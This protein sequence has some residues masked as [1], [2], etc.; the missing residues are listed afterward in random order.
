MK[1]FMKI[2]W[3]KIFHRK[4]IEEKLFTDKGVW[5]SCHCKKCDIRWIEPFK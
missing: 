2:A 3:C 4:H 5:L 1:I